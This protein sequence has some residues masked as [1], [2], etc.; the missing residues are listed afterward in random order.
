M[1]QSWFPRFRRNASF[2]QAPDKASGDTMDISALDS[3]QVDTLV[4]SLGYVKTDVGSVL[5]N[6][7]I[8]VGNASNVGTDVA[9]SGD[10]TIANT[11]AT[12]VAAGAITNAKVNAGAAIAKSKLAFPYLQVLS[13]VVAAADLVDG[14]GAVGTKTFTGSIPKG[15]ILVGSKVIPTAGLA[16]DVSAV[17]T[18][19]DGTDVDRLNT[20]TINVFAT[21]ADGV[22]SGA[23]SGDLLVTA[24][25]QP[26][27]TVTSDSDI[28]LV[29]AG[30]GSLTVSLYYIATA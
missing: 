20:G 2:S 3:A 9:M 7:H 18:I 25:F 21:A 11:G 26:V 12:A 19:G 16:G 14:G 30:G 5:T 6:G 23:P 28:T 15:A 29:I 27:V 24:A 22:Q 10:V 1:G 8:I 4:G 13:E 17:S